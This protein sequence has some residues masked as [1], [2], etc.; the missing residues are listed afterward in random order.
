MLPLT[1]F[2]LGIPYA[3]VA[4]DPRAKRS[5]AAALK[6]YVGIWIDELEARAVAQEAGRVTRNHTYRQE[7]EYRRMLEAE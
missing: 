3:I 2:L 4:I 7:I 6:K 1:I 5:L